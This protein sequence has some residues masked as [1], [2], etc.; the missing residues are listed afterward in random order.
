MHA[1]LAICASVGERAAFANIAALNDPYLAG[2]RA[3]VSGKLIGNQTEGALETR[4]ASDLAENMAYS[5]VTG[6]WHLNIF[7]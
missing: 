4:A 7:F 1:H 3:Y 2:R 6:C 5:T